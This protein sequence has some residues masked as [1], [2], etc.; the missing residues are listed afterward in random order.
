MKDMDIRKLK[1]LVNDKSR[2]AKR[3]RKD[4]VQPAKVA[5]V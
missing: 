4:S 1:A 5:P 2:T 3:L